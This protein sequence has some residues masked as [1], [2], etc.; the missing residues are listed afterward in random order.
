[1]AS[2]LRH[3]IDEGGVVLICSPRVKFFYNEKLNK[4]SDKFWLR[5]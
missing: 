5:N 1:M 3:M 2:Y 4:K